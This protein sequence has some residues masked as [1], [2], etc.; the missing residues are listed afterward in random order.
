MNTIWQ[1]KFDEAGLEYTASIANLGYILKQQGL[2]RERLDSLTNEIKRMRKL[3]LVIKQTYR[4]VAEQLLNFQRLINDLVD[5]YW[6]IREVHQSR[7]EKSIE[8]EIL[9]S[10]NENNYTWEGSIPTR[11]ATPYYQRTTHRNTYWKSTRTYPT[12]TY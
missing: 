1:Q 2:T 4:P 12:G 7:L 3:L 8:N 6:K 5:Q 10:N 9:I 11:K